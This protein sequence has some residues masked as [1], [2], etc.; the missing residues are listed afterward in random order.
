VVVDGIQRVRA[1]ELPRRVG[2]KTF[3]LV[4]ALL[5]MGSLVAAGAWIRARAHKAVLKAMPDASAPDASAPDAAP[6]DA[7]P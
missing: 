4:G 6:A 2:W 5:G 1:P 3:A 7:S